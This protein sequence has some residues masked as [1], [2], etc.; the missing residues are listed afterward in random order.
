VPRAID[1]DHLPALRERGE[2][3]DPLE[4]IAEPTEHKE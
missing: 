3:R 1:G 4:R 2:D